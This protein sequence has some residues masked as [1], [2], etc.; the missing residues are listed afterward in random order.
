MVTMSATVPCAGEGRNLEHI[1]NCELGI[2]I[3]GVLFE[4]V[5]QNLTGLGA[6][7]AEEIRSG[8]AEMLGPLPPGAQRGIEGEVTEEVERIG[9]GLLGGSASHRS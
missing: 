5:I 3:H 1:W 4:Q 9:V 6:I 8:L 2:P 7:A